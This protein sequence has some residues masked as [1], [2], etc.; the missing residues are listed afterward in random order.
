MFM[1][2]RYS[3]LGTG[4]ENPHKLVVRMQPIKYL[5]YNSPNVNEPVRGARDM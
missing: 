1:V 2:V 3:Y 4:Q 5:E